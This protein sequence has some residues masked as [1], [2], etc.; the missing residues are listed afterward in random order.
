V[1]SSRAPAKNFPDH[2]LVDVRCSLALTS[3]TTAARELKA[4]EVQQRKYDKAAAS[5]ARKKADA[6]AKAGK[7]AAKEAL[8]A[9]K[10]RVVRYFQVLEDSTGSY[11]V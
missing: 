3:L 1:S 11:R 7:K 10:H 2:Y 9:E 8:R 6:D 5:A 4:R